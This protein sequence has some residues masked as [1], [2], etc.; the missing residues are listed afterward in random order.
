MGNKELS[1]KVADPGSREFQFLSPDSQ[2]QTFEGQNGLWKEVVYIHTSSDF[3][4]C[5]VFRLQLAARLSAFRKNPFA[6]TAVTIMEAQLA[7]PPKDISQLDFK[8]IMDYTPKH[9]FT[10]GSWLIWN[11]HIGTD[12]AVKP[13]QF[14]IEDKYSEETVFKVR[15]VSFTMPLFAHTHLTPE[16]IQNWGLLYTPDVYL[17]LMEPF[18]LMPNKQD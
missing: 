16:N 3:V 13:F 14:P 15:G 9:L 7:D 11:Q 1:I 4:Y 18:G 6:S 5:K 12:E 8:Q 10:A 2:I 17:Q